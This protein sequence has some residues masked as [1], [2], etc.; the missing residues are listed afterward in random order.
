MPWRQARIRKGRQ[1]L[2]GEPT[3]EGGGPKAVNPPSQCRGDFQQLSDEDMQQGCYH[4]HWCLRAEGATS[5]AR[6]P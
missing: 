1:L 5:D 4:L 6:E 2:S 3:R